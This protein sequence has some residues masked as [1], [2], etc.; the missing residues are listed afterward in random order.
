[1]QGQQGIQGIQGEP[2]EQGEQGIQGIQGEQG[3]QGEPGFSPSVEVKTQTDTEYVL[4]I[5]DET[6]SYDTP[7]LKGP[8]GDSGGGGG[9]RVL[10]D[11]IECSLN[12]YYKPYAT[13]IYPL[14]FLTN[15]GKYP[16][17]L[18]S[19]GSVEI[20]LPVGQ[21][22]AAPFE[23][24]RFDTTNHYSDGNEVFS[25]YIDEVRQSK[26]LINFSQYATSVGYSDIPIWAKK[27]FRLLR[28]TPAD[29][30]LIVDGNVVLEA[31]QF[32]RPGNSKVFLDDDDDEVVDPKST[33]IYVID[34]SIVYVPN[35]VYYVKYIIK[36]V[37]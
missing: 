6:Q 16:V 31:K 29:V 23:T 24:M 19:D 17:E 20:T 36:N 37:M 34:D 2:G 13:P 33:Y 1:M 18:Y 8:K 5:T 30:Q 27:A 15:V 10:V 22:S 21:T 26:I 32:M 7:N 14:N 9:G 3:E 11:S 28:W 12:T 35:K 4:T 25:I